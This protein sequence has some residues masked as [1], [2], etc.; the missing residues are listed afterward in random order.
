[1]GPVGLH[2]DPQLAAHHLGVAGIAEL[3]LLDDLLEHL[4]DE[5]QHDV[6]ETAEVAIEDGPRETRLAHHL[7]D[8][9][10]AVAALLEQ[11]VGGRDYPPPSLR[12]GHA[13]SARVFAD[14]ARSTWRPE[15]WHTIATCV[16]REE[17]AHEADNRRS[18]C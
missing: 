15:V 11:A 2:R 17:R 14:A 3:G 13:R 18:P 7:L 8:A 10:V 6:G 4:V 5:R 16:A 12:R 9:E 1:M